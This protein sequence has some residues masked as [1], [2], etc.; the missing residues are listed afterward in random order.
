MHNKLSDII[1]ILR[2]GFEKLNRDEDT[3]NK[4]IRPIAFSNTMNLSSIQLETRKFYEKGINENISYIEKIIDDLLKFPPHHAKHDEQLKYFHQIADFSK[5]IFIMT[6]YPE[7]EAEIEK[8][9]ELRNVIQITKDVIEECGYYPR[10]ASDDRYHPQLW[11]NVELYLLGCSK[12]VAIM[13]DRYNSELNPNVA[14]ECG[15]MRAMG[16]DVI[17]LFEN[18]FN[19]HRADWSG[20]IKSSF[21]WDNPEKGIKNAVK[22]WLTK[23]NLKTNEKI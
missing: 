16:K 13:E 4:K 20:L 19:H 15:W 7:E 9:D 6:K 8:N 2:L 12:G 10:L 17:F 3:Y 18:N 22:N 1:E 21:N 23:E 11:D 14:M 5:S